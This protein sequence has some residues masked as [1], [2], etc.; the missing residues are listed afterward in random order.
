MTQETWRRKPELNYSKDVFDIVQFGSSVIEGKEARDVDIAVIFK[1]IPIKEQ[2]IQA[3]Q[4]KR[5]IQA[6]TDKEVHINSFD[7]I[8]LFE[9]S[10]FSREGILF[11]GISLVN[12]QHFSKK[13]GM[14]P[15]LQIY[16]SLKNLE[17]KVKIRFN[18]LLNGRGGKYG[19]L[20]EYSG[21][22]VKPGLVEISPRHEEIF[23]K[24]M[25]EIT[26]DFSIKKIFEVEK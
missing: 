1:K 20:R 19:L 5:Q 14:T 21:K 25:S 11:Y 7:L 10:N 8:S 3:Q 16:Y 22:L 9:S 6:F 4:I 13:L 18:Y 12:E 24:A 17:K 2:L 15:R 26:S 23:K